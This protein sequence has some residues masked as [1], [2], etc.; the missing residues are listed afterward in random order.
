MSISLIVLMLQ[1]DAIID[2][3]IVSSSV[4]WHS[5]ALAGVADTILWKTRIT[6]SPEFAAFVMADCI[7][8]TGVPPEPEPHPDIA[9]NL[10]GIAGG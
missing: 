1:P 6:H 8:V 3:D 10:Y 7:V 9:R 5:I 4:S 2:A